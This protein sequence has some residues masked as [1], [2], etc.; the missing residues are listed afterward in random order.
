MSIGFQAALSAVP[1]LDQ[2][3]EEEAALTAQVAQ[4]PDA[5]AVGS[6]MDACRQRLA[7]AVDDVVRTLP[8]ALRS[9][10]EASR[11]VAYALVGLVDGRMLHH[12]SGGLQ[13]WRDQLLESE[14]YGSALAGQDVVDR[15]RAAAHGVPD[16]GS[17]LMSGHASVLAPFYLAVFRAGFEGALR[18]DAVG[19][20]ALIAALE[21]ACAVHQAGRFDVPPDSRPR[22]WGLA[23]LPLA[24]LGIAA[25]L[26]AGF[27]AYAALSGDS[28]ADADR[29]AQRLSTRSVAIDGRAP[30]ERSIGPSRL[31]APDD[32][33]DDL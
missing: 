8:A 5:A 11:A 21:E 23:P 17:G 14:L 15:A 10:P 30:L 32:P 24:G 31:R 25:W 12:P 3:D 18:G 29:L 1:F 2:L 20:A 33:R 7:Q 27:A 4:T 6:A 22:K 9:D 13:R 28:L 26:L 19:R 16:D